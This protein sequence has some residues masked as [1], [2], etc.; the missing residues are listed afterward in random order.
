M[1]YEHEYKQE[2][3]FYTREEHRKGCDYHFWFGVLA[4]VLSATTVLIV[5]LALGLYIDW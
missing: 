4:G 3:L 2:C 1:S 5:V